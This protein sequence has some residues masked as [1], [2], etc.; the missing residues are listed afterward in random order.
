VRSG[1]TGAEHHER[2][3]SYRQTCAAGPAIPA[4]RPT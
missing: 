1:H 3:A 2:S 4:S